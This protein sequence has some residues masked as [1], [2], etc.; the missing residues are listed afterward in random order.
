MRSILADLLYAYAFVLFIR[1][2]LS[3]VIAYSR[4]DSLVQ[5]DRMLARVTDPVLNPI[6]RAMPQTMRIDWSPTIAIAGCYIAA[7]LIGG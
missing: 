6:R 2:M 3:W 7:R 4:N 5:V 1:A